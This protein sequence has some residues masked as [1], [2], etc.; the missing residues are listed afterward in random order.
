[1]KTKFKTFTIL[2]IDNN[3]TYRDKTTVTLNKVIDNI[4]VANSG[5]EAIKIYE[6]N[7]EDIDLVLFS[8]D[9]DHDSSLKVLKQIRDFDKKLFIILMEENIEKNN[10]LELVKYRIWDVLPKSVNIKELITSIYST[11]EYNRNKNKINDVEAQ[12][13]IDAINKVAIVSKTDLKGII[14]YVNDIFCEIAKYTKDELLGQPHNIIRHPDMPK[15]AFAQL[16]EVISRGETWQ[17][18]VKNMA[19][20]GSAYFVNA[21]ISPIY[22]ASGE[23]IVE[24]IAIRFLTTEDETEKREFRKKVIVNLQENK[25]REYEQ[26]LKIE[27]LEK[28]I[29]SV[30]GLKEELEHEHDRNQKLLS[31]VKY[32]EE[33]I[34]QIEFLNTKTTNEIKVE[35]LSV[36]TINKELKDRNKRLSLDNASKEEMIEERN[37][38][39]QDLEVRNTEQSHRIRELRDVIENGTK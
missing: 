1:M 27:S 14:T 19:K 7:K 16:W 28:D 29:K 20:D 38:A 11:Y 13:Y 12:S 37:H 32:Y 2:F 3:I 9:D 21:T 15:D 10:L 35:N 6:K 39:I 36:L 8:I 25:R 5:D 4:F 24:Y 33:K 23:N 18:K 22:D 31:Q 26:L 17:G 34:S 30:R